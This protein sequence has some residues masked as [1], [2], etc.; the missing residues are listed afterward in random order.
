MEK[1][2]EEAPMNKI[3]EDSAWTKPADMLISGLDVLIK[4]LMTYTA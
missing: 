4:I 1:H 2:F 3:E